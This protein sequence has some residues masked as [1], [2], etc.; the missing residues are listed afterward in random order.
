MESTG[1]AGEEP[2][3]HSLGRLAGIL[4]CFGALL[5]VPSVLTLDPH[6]PAWVF[7]LIVLAFLGG[8]ACFGIPWERIAAQWFHLV[9]VAASLTVT[10]GVL[11][12]EVQGILSSWLYMLIGIMV[13]YSFPSRRAVGAHVALICLCLAAPL[14]D[15]FIGTDDALRNV[16]VS[17]PSL[18]AAVAMVTFA[19][20][21]LEA[22][23]RAYQR[24]AGV[25]PLTGVGNYR[26]LYERLD[27]EIARH[28]RHGRRFAVVL[29]DL[30]G[31]K[32]INE[33]YGHLE[34]DRVLRAVGRVLAAAVREQDTV[35]RQ[36]GDELSVLAPETTASEVPALTQRLREALATVVVGERRL[37]AS[38]GWAIYPE[39]GAT[40]E[41]L[42]AAADD[43]L[44]QSKPGTLPKPAAEPPRGS[45]RLP[46]LS[47]P[48]RAASA[49]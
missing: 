8:I 20:E 28:E 11:G 22:G 31:F 40:T 46:S 12:S 25:D 17:I 10:A 9:P 41:A 44:L 3:R 36:G 30:D 45:R 5:S 42:L 49:R 33:S 29:L 39:D 4:F 18:I 35:A 43:A 7:G 14:A 16:A 27:Y 15:P 32:E 13:A 34:G 21:R 26:T 6:P 2:G 19:R 38:T 24:L 48:G 23:K 1:E 47:D 37:T